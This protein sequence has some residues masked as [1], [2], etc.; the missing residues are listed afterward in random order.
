MTNT[1]IL[2]N[3]KVQYFY[4]GKLLRTSKSFYK[5]ALVEENECG[6]RTMKFSNSLETINTYF[7]FDKFFDDGKTPTEL[8]INLIRTFNKNADENI[9]K[10]GATANATKVYSMN[11]P[12]K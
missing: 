12:L 2:K 9:I 10:E 4:K 8:R 11:I 6:I 3:G 5:Y 7:L 1:K